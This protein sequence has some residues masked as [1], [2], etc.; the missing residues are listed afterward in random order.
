MNTMTMP[1]FIGEASF[2]KTTRFYRGTGSRPSGDAGSTVVTPQLG[3]EG[4]CYAGAAICALGCGLNVFC[5]AGCEAGLAL[6]LNACPSSGGVGGP[7][8]PCP[9]GTRCC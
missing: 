3:R 5:Q 2:Y 6:C 7:N 8:P 1:G 4:T 9:P